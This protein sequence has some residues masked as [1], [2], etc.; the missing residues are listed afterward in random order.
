MDRCRNWNRLGPLRYHCAISKC[1]YIS[2]RVAQTINNYSTFAINRKRGSWIWAAPA[3][4]PT[5]GSANNNK[6][7]SVTMVP[8]NIPLPPTPQTQ[9]TSPVGHQPST[10]SHHQQMQTLPVSLN[11]NSLYSSTNDIYEHLP[12]ENHHMY[13]LTYEDT[14][15]TRKNRAIQ[16]LPVDGN[17]PRSPPPSPPPGVTVN[18]VTVNGFVMA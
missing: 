8:P 16:P 18:G 1:V 17:R 12:G 14:A 5:N 15:S 13:D 7:R 4:K 11:G 9:F 6:K 10:Y 2:R 3:D